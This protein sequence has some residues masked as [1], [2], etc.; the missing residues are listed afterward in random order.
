M[1]H[2]FKAYLYIVH[3]L[4][5]YSMPLLC[6]HYYLHFQNVLSLTVCRTCICTSCPSRSVWLVGRRPAH[7]IQNIFIIII[8]IIIIVTIII[9]I[10]I[11]IITTTSIKI[12]IT[13]TT[14]TIPQK[15]W[16]FH[17]LAQKWPKMAHGGPNMTQNGPKRPK[18]AQEWPNKFRPFVLTEKVV[19][20]TFSL[21]EC[22]VM[23]N[24]Q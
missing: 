12:N 15:N 14:L 4:H 10:I 20:Q 16:T 24:A 18:M 19:P 9:V 7:N 13:I 5:F 3:N 22:L 1:L 6:I 11:I 21:L 8:I 2:F 17:N 23:V